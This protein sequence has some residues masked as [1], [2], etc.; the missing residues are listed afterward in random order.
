MEER[1][2]NLLKERFGKKKLLGLALIL[3]G[4]AVFSM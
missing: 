3:V 2:Q 1:I 4:I